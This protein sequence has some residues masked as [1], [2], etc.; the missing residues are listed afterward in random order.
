MAPW[1]LAHELGI[2]FYARC[3]IQSFHHENHENKMQMFMAV[4]HLSSLIS[5]I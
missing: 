4:Q 5:Q 3:K 2:Y 1:L